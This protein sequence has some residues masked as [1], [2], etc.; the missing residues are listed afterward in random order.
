MIDAPDHRV[1]V[2]EHREGP[3]L[4]A[5]RAGSVWPCV[6]LT[7]TTCDWTTVCVRTLSAAHARGHL[8]SIAEALT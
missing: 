3:R 7:C 5:P 2:A 1:V 8:A 4:H 6:R